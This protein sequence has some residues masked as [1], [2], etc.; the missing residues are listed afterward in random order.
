MEDE[1]L[2]ERWRK[3]VCKVQA[4]EF[5]GSQPLDLAAHSV[6]PDAFLCIFRCL[7]TAL[8]THG[9][10][11]DPVCMCA[12]NPV[13]RRQRLTLLQVSASRMQQPCGK[14]NAELFRLCSSEAGPGFLI[15][16]TQVSGHQIAAP[17]HSVL[18]PLAEVAGPQRPLQIWLTSCE[19]PWQHLF[20][21]PWPQCSRCFLP[22]L[23][24]NTIHKG[25]TSSRY[26]NLC[27]KFTP[28]SPLNPTLH[29]I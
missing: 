6:P 4:C 2:T 7:S 10:G 20:P 28:S 14:R 21:P 23:S 8:S 12:A 1:V 18:V 24:H 26:G 16:L 19:Q 27:A 13:H 11:G 22:P 15:T 5:S 17:S 25:Q 3:Q 9:E 29:V